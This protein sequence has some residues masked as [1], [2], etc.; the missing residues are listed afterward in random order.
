MHDDD[1]DDH[2]EQEPA[3]DGLAFD[4]EAT[5][6]CPYCREQVEITLDPDG[7][8]VQE[9]VEDCEVC[10]RPWQLHVSFDLDGAA[11]VTVEA[12]S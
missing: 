2:D 7:G 10:C 5:V 6:T 1:Q 12:A 11:E 3:E 4:T 9:Y 8:A